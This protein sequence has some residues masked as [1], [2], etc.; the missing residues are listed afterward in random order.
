MSRNYDFGIKK[1]RAIV[2]NLFNNSRSPD[3]PYRRGRP[4]FLKQ[5]IG[6]P[7]TTKFQSNYRGI[8]FSKVSD[9]QKNDIYSHDK[10]FPSGSFTNLLSEIR[11]SP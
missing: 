11:T 1:N 7:N 10:L 4:N 3:S 9:F 5:S 6:M 8:H 2:S